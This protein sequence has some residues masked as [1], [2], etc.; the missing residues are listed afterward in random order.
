MKK[1]TLS[2]IGVG[3]GGVGQIAEGV[4]GGIT[5][6][7]QLIAGAIQR[8]QAQKLLPSET[9]PTQISMI[10]ELKRM[11]LG[12]QTGAEASSYKN[13]VNTGLAGQ[14]KAIVQYSGGGTGEILNNLGT[15]QS[16]AMGAYNNITSSLEKNRIGLLGMEDQE[17]NDV[18]QRKLDVQQ[19]IYLQK[20]AQGA[21]NSKV[22]GQNAMAGM[23]NIVNGAVGGK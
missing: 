22:G 21:G 11:R 20:M 23:E 14:T 1:I 8:K 4:V 19:E 10:D 5:G 6:I 18:D 13:L 16:S 15:A 3:A 9:D 2:L 7:G 17:I 12:Y